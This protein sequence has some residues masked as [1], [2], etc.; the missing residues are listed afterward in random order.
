MLL[1]NSPKARLIIQKFIYQPW[2]RFFFNENRVIQWFF[3]FSYAERNWLGHALFKFLIFEQ[4][5]LNSLKCKFAKQ[6]WNFFIIIFSVYGAYKN[7]SFLRTVKFSSVA[8]IRQINKKKKKSKILQFK[9]KT[10]IFFLF[11]WT[12]IRTI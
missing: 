4:T 1:F 3:S 11:T 8:K 2:S 9:N 6:S 7:P 12:I 10:R 5:F